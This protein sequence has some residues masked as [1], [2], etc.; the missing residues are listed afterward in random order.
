MSVFLDADWSWYGGDLNDDIRLINRGISKGKPVFVI[1]DYWEVYF[2]IGTEKEIKDKITVFIK[3]REQEDIENEII[4]K[5][6]IEKEKIKRIKELEK[7]L[8]TL[9]GK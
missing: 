5:S 3:E 6:R 7:E 1:T 8:K 4:R 2:V 9:K